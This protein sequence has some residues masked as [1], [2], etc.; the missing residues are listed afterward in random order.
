M[1]AIAFEKINCN[2]VKNFV[3]V[4]IVIFLS[5]QCQG[6]DLP[7]D[8]AKCKAG[9]NACIRDKIM[10]LFKKFPKGN[11][12]FGMPNISALSKNNVVI[13]RASPDAPVQLNFKFLDYTCY[14]FENAVVVNTTG[15]T[16]KPKVIEA[17]L[18][19][20]SLRMGGEYEGSGKILFL[21]LNG[22]GKGLVEL[23]DCTAFTK[24]EIRLE[25]RNN[26]KNYAKII[27]M[28]VDLEPKKN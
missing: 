25:K 8:I 7:S 6:A 16:K 28:K 5:L 22:K 18:R 17:H 20:P 2:M 23:V 12:E 27:K 19:V 1:Q 10:E 13:S 3:I 14:G 24:F 15:W 11:P 9:D 21:T 26:G 4:T